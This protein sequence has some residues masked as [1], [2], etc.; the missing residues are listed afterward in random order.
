MEIQMENKTKQK[1]NKFYEKKLDH[2]FYFSGTFEKLLVTFMRSNQTK[3][4]Y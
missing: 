3:I 1:C 2:A 4:F